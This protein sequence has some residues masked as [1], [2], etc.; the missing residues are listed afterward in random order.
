MSGT[1]GGWT[2]EE[3]ASAGAI[4]G[5]AGTHRAEGLAS[6]DT[7]GGTKDAA[8]QDLVPEVPVVDTGVV[9]DE[10]VTP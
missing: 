3:E 8:L 2:L 7:L 4:G 1:N 10:E 6:G 5:H 9:P